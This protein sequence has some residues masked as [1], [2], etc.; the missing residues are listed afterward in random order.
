MPLKEVA[1]QGMT[2]TVDQ[3][4]VIPAVTPLVATILVNPPT[5]TKVTATALVHRQDDTVTVS[6]ITVPA[7]GATIPD[8]GPYT[9]KIVAA[10]TKTKAEGKLVARLDDLTE[11][12]SATPK[13]PGAPPTDYPVTFKCKI[14]AAG[15]TKVKAQ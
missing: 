7:A 12:F 1:V 2:V 6:A 4:S 14:T 8:P 9:K 3:T 5:G 15:Q 13:I 10:A 11:T